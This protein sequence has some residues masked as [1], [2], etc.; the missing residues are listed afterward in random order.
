MTE[1]SQ[2]R[3]GRRE[4][5]DSRKLIQARLRLLQQQGP[6][7]GIPFDAGPG[8]SEQRQ[9]EARLLENERQMEEHGSVRSALEYELECLRK[10]LD[11]SRDH[12]EFENRRIR[13]STLNV[14]LD[15]DS[16]EAGA[17]VAFTVAR[18]SSPGETPRA[19]VIGRLG[20]SDM[21][22]VKLNIA[23]AER[24]L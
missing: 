6:G 10:V 8:T 14:V 7:L 22:Q 23:N 19:F 11:D 17:D 9:L 2:A 3:E 4:L 15:E 12:L 1:I 20:R 21:P 18:F 13:L 5:E 24:F 16:A